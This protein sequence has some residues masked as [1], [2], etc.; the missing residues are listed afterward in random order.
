[1]ILEDYS[2]APELAEPGD[3]SDTELRAAVTEALG[4]RTPGGDE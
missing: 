1:M 3:L 2:I 4:I